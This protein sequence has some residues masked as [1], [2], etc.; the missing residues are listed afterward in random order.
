ARFSSR[1]PSGDLW[2]RPDVTA[3][4]YDIVSAQSATGTALA[5]NDLNRGT[6]AD[7]LY[8]TGSGTSMAAPAAAGSAALLLDAYRQ[9]YDGASPSGA[10]GTDGLTA[11]ADG[12]LKAALMN[13]ARANQDESRWILT[14][15]GDTTT[16]GCPPL[17]GLDPLEAQVCSFADLIASSVNGSL[18]SLTL[19]EVRNG[20]ARPTVG[21]LAEG[22]GKINVPAAAPALTDGLVAYTAAS[23]S[24]DDA[25]TGHQDFQGI[26]QIGA[27]S[28]GQPVSQRLVLHNA[29]DAPQVTV[30]FV[31]KPLKPSDT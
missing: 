19:D 13:S 15:D 11:P 5:A 18:G 7:P 22:A 8:V 1:G 2:L 20:A 17:A 21:E 28:P 6:R 30:S 3:P 23:G 14:I 9:R 27:V 29:P 26:W 12:L 4:G 24:G 25:G 16:A 10:S 31:F